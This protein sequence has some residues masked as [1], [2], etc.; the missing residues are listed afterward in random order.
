M[1]FWRLS[2]PV[3]QACQLASLL[4]TPATTP[5]H[6]LSEPAVPDAF[7]IEPKVRLKLVEALEDPNALMVGPLKHVSDLPNPL[8]SSEAWALERAVPDAVAPIFSNVSSA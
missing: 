2:R 8:S 4:G 1:S 6:L 5:G 3:Q 7:G